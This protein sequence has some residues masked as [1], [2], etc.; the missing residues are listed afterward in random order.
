MNTLTKQILIHLI[1]ES[2][3][4]KTRGRPNKED[5]DHYIDVIYNVLRS[6]MQWSNIKERLYYKTYYKKFIKWSDEG[7]IEA[8]HTCLMKTMERCNF[9]D[10]RFANIFIDSSSIRNIHG[11][12]EIGRSNSLKF[13]NANK[14]SIVVNSNGLILGLKIAAGNIH[15]VQLTELTLDKVSVKIIGSRLIGDKGYV[16]QNMKTKLKNQ[17]NITLVHPCKQNQRN[18]HLTDQ[19]KQDLRKRHIVENCFSWI[20]KYR[21]LQLR[22]DRKA[23]SFVSFCYLAILDICSK[24]LDRIVK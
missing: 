9:F 16:S 6:G 1:D 14:I 12:D 5:T 18:V 19:D 10:E 22:Y 3:S 17:R 20:K 8:A 23:S 24:K 7:I 13:K 15:D 2:N 21:R 4:T 11:I